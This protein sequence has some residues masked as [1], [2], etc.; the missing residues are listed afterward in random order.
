MVNELGGGSQ[1]FE[2]REEDISGEVERSD[3]SVTQIMDYMQTTHVRGEFI[4]I[5]Q[6]LQSSFTLSWYGNKGKL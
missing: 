2:R 4:L 3:R 5:K 6:V 1:N